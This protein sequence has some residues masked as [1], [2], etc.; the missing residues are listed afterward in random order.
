MKSYDYTRNRKVEKLWYKVI[1]YSNS[2]MQ[3]NM[4]EIIEGL[5]KICELR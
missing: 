2:Y 3:Q 4:W 5:K 1:R